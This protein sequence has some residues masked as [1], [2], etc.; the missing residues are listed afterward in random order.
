MS[1]LMRLWL[2]SFLFCATFVAKAAVSDI[3]RIYKSPVSLEAIEVCYGGG[4]AA[5]Q[6][7]AITPKEWKKI[8]ALFAANTQLNETSTSEWERKKIALAIGLLEELVGA[9]TGTTS[10]RAGTFDNE[11]FPGQ[12]DCNDEAI[13]T[14]SYIRLMQ[15]QG[16]LK[17]HAVE[18]M[19]TRNFFFNGWPHTTAVMHEIDSGKRFAVDSWFYDNG[20]PATIV[21]F[22][23]WKDDYVPE[24]SPIRQAHRP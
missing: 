16:L 6:T 4:C 7:I 3:S 2:C 5:S 20:L 14:T 15:Q 22:E 11:D 19:R 18:D 12:L 24:D 9:K 8:E 21:P 13:N 17:W 10:D 1:Y 23:A